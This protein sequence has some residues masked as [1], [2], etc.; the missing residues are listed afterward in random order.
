MECRCPK[1]LY[2]GELNELYLFLT[3]FSKIGNFVRNQLLDG[4]QQ[5]EFPVKPTAN[6]RK[7]NCQL[8]KIW[9]AV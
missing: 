7:L 1:E 3:R 8:I 5:V 6:C 9:R 2:C 4:Y